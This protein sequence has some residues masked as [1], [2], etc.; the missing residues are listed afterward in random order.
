MRTARPQRTGTSVRSAEVV[1]IGAGGVIG[2]SVAY[3]LAA[4]GLR[5]SPR[6]RA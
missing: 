2:A 5:S 1:V 3:H 6:A 4:E